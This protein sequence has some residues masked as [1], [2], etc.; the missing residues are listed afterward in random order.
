MKNTNGN[1]PKVTKDPE[2]DD[3]ETTQAVLTYWKLVSPN[4]KP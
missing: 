1:T 3:E 2:I 4:W